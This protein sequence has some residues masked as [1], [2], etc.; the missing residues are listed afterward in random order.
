MLSTA[1]WVRR[2]C[3]ACDVIHNQQV[4]LHSWPSLAIAQ[5]LGKPCLLRFACSGP[6]GDLAT[7]IRERFGSRQVTSLR[8][9]DRFIAL[10]RGAAAELL[11]YRLPPER[12]RVIPN[13]VDAQRFITQPWQPVSELD[14]VRLLFV[15]RLDQQ[16]GLDVLLDALT[17]T[18]DRTRFRLRVV[19]EGPQGPRLQERVR[20][21]KL[22]SLVSFCGRQTDVVPW[23][24]WSELVVLPSRFEGMPNVVL[25]AM[26]CGR[27]VVDGT[28]DL[29]ESGVGGW[30]VP[31]ED[32][33]ALA[34][35]LD[36]VLTLRP[37]F[38][39]VG[40]AGRKLVE[41]AYSLR[42]VAATYLREYEAMLSQRSDGLRGR[43]TTARK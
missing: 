14:P 42:E 17:L 9:A 21:A 23:Y 5:K 18:R 29:L 30:L 2:L 34:G 15:G 33:Q 24:A 16:K 27:P 32:P 36:E 4:A 40:L 38:A 41:Q 31:S 7:L 43:R 37:N 25:E 1:R 3:S 12:T 39:A 8:A 11:A 6:G 10:S 20:D 35:R 19:G 28:S 13:G 22:D 26:A